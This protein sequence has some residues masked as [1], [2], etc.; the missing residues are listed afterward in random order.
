M[1]RQHTGLLMSLSLL[2]LVLIISLFFT[3]QIRTSNAQAIAYW[4]RLDG[5]KKNVGGLSSRYLVTNTSLST[6]TTAHYFYDYADQTKGYFPDSIGA[7]TGKVYGL[8]DVASLPDGYS[9]YVIIEADAQITAT[10]L[11]D[12]PIADFTAGPTSGLAPL[13]VTFTNQSTDYTASLWN[14]GDETTGTLQSP[15]HTYT[16]AGVYTVSLTVS[17]PG[18]TDT[19][20]RTSYIAV[21]GEYAVYLP[22]ALRNR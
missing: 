11:P 8:A 1:N 22:L 9:G 4:V 19:L 14:Y 7:G 5:V 3:S 2:L 10:L 13:V 6:V 18:G 15:T 17:G 21:Q 12:P 20:T 16:T